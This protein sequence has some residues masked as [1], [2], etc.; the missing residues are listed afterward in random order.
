VEKDHSS[1]DARFV[2]QKSI[3]WLL[4]TVA[5][6]ED[7]AE[8]NGTLSGTTFIHRVNT[9]GGLAPETGCTSAADVGRTAFVPYTADYFF[10]RHP[11]AA[12]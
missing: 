12:R 3:A 10:Y 11:G 9:L 4:L 7:G 6:G 2:A 8:G 1:T 5:N